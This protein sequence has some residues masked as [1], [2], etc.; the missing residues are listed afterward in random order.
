VPLAIRDRL[1]NSESGTA[2]A[3][4]IA[5]DTSLAFLVEASKGMNMYASGDVVFYVS[6]NGVTDYS[7][8]LGEAPVTAT[9]LASA[10]NSGLTRYWIGYDRFS[11]PCLAPRYEYDADVGVSIYLRD[12]AGNSLT[13]R[14]Y[15]LRTQSVTEYQAGSANLLSATI[16]P[17]GSDSLIIATTDLGNTSETTLQGATMLFNPNDG[18]VTPYFTALDGAPD[19]ELA[20]ARAVGIPISIQP[21]RIFQS[22]L[23][24][25]IP[26]PDDVDVENLGVYGFDGSDWTLLCSA[27]GRIQPGMEGWLIPHWNNGISKDTLNSGN[28]SGVTIW[29]FRS[30]GFVAGAAAGE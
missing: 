4:K 29:A 8:H 21:L 23:T 30:G 28:P 27:N 6:D 11:D 24:L 26:C 18:G 20:G 10:P 12:T 14:Q 5:V 3:T 19:L 15:Q 9:E 1:P 17:S 16:E 2:G 7:R 25:F 13:S 22:G